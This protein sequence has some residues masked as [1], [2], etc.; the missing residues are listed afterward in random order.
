MPNKSGGGR[1][2]Y[3]YW[4]LT[5]CFIFNVVGSGCGPISFSFFVTALEKSFGWGRTEIM[6]AFTFLFVF[7]AVAAPISGKLVHVIGSRIVIAVGALFSAGGYLL[8]S[9]MSELW[10]YYIG[11]SL[12]GI[13]TAA[14]GP[15][16]CSLIVSK[17]FVQRRGMAI[18]AMSM[19]A[20]TA[21]LIFTP[22]V[23]V[24]LLPHFGWSNTYLFLTGIT[25]IVAVPLAALVVRTDPAEMGLLPDG[26]SPSRITGIDEIVTHQG[27][28]F[29][30]AL[31]TRAFWMLVLAVLLISVHMGVMQ[32]QIPHLEDLGFT[33]GIVASAMSIVAMMSVVG[34]VAFGW[35]SE[36]IPLKASSV[37]GIL[38]IV[39]SVMVLLYVRIDSPVWLIWSYATLLGLGIGSW[40][41]NTSLLASSHFGILAYGTIF[42]VFM[43]FQ[44]LGAAISPIICGYF[45]DRTGSYEM[46]FIT[47]LV[48]IA[49]GIPSILAVNRP[50]PP[51]ESAEKQ[52]RLAS[53]EV[54]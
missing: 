39:F 21:G 52:G 35:L 3:G 44:M 31:S 32:S 38:L 16:V 14:I 23:I 51:S 47:L 37:L 28:P 2:F 7:S 15:V 20:G 10:Q 11:Y 29:R 30:S 26:K 8:V 6:T 27:M 36:K 48:I 17:W 9:Q 22:L 24:Y 40:M 41:T 18:G 4:V 25:A 42:G 5:A 45:Y 50:R 33:S 46:A 43:A 53:V 34:T 12:V 1:I 19:G 13:G 54:Q 49:L